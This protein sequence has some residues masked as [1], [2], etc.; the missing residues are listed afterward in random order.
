MTSPLNG[1]SALFSGWAVLCVGIS[2][3]D[4]PFVDGVKLQNVKND[5]GDVRV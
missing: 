3:T 2:K 5:G 1:L 4:D